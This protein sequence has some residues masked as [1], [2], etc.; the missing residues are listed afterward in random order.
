MTLLNDKGRRVIS[1]IYI[2]LVKETV[3]YVTWLNKIRGMYSL[4]LCMYVHCTVL[5]T[6]GKFHLVQ[7]SPKI[8]ELSET[9]RTNVLLTVYTINQKIAANGRMEN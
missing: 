5:T 1:Y 6:R 7:F 8:L 4:Q 2:Y 3:Q 9:F